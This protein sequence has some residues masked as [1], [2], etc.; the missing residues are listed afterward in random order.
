MKAFPARSITVLMSALF[1]FLMLKFAAFGGLLGLFLLFLMIV[2]M[3]LS[4]VL[5]N[6]ATVLVAAPVAINI[7]EKIGVALDVVLVCLMI[8][9]TI[10]AAERGDGQLAVAGVVVHDDLA[11]RQGGAD[12]QAEGRVP[13]A[14]RA[15]DVQGEVDDGARGRAGR[16][17]RG[18]QAGC[19][20]GSRSSRA[21]PS[22]TCT[23]R[24][25]HPRRSPATRRR[26]STWPRGVLVPWRPSGLRPGGT[27]PGQRAAAD[28]YQQSVNLQRF[29]FALAVDANL[30]F[31]IG[32]FSFGDPAVEMK[33]HALPLQHLLQLAADLTV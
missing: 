13:L 7:A 24:G 1:I 8:A 11:R 4:D 6:V 28:A 22:A 23:H 10:D 9:I 33:F 18:R 3:T 15:G 27:D 26:S 14:F 25:S 31:S 32:F 21:S 17:A 16:G 5:N 30:H 12:G 2:T 19:G 20:A 29:C